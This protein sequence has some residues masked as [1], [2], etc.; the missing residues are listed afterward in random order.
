[1][2]HKGARGREICPFLISRFISKRKTM[3]NELT[4]QAR[5]FLV[6]SLLNSLG[7]GLT[8][9]V[10]VVYLHRIAGLSLTTA[11]LVL[12]WM[13]IVGLA[14][15]PIFGTLVDR[16]GPRIV[17]LFAILV[18]AAAVASWSLVRSASAAYLVGFFVTVGAAGIWAPQTTMMARMVPEDFR[19]KLF[20]L[21]FMM[22]N[23]GLGIGGLISS[24][25]VDINVPESFTRLFILD[26]FSYLAF[27]VIVFTL[28]QAGGPITR[29]EN[30]TDDGF[31]EILRDKP[32]LKIQ[33]V[34]VLLLSCGYAALDAGLPPLLTEY[35][36]LNLNKLG[37]IWAVNTGVIV[38][39]Q[40]FVI[41]KL[42]G[43]SRT[44]SIAVIG[45][46]WA[47]SWV[48]IGF[49]V[50]IEKAFLGALVG[51]GVFAIGEMV[52]STIGSSITNDMAPEHLRG[53]YNSTDSLVWVTA[54]AIGPAISGVMLQFKLTYEWIALLVIGQLTGGLLGLRMRK[55]LTDKQDGILVSN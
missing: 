8:I 51:A 41:N 16:Y 42:Q 27:F 55:H 50:S 1:M 49:G 48:I 33:G 20:G 29:D 47:L 23:L 35:G 28:R 25:I 30:T 2:D 36:G 37:P 12:S 40:I 4:P 32:F 39:G 18:E 54:A 17:M 53:R 45:M 10:I 38:I 9:T 3:L 21:H 5:R 11:S 7:G 43:R 52:W 31:R 15:G 46:I 6:G 22:L 13:A 19:Q 44:K 26:A 14:V 24:L 34:K